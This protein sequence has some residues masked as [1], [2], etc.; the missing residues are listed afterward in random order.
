MTSVRSLYEPIADDLE[1]V[2]DTL[3][4]A[5]R[6]DFVPLQNMLEQVLQRSGKRLRPAIA[7]LAGSFGKYDT[8][9]QVALATSI[10]LLHTATLVHDDVIDS[11]ATRR[12]QPTANAT[13]DNAA[14]VMLGDYMFAHAAELVAR[15]GNL[16]VIRLFAETLMTMAKGEL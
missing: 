4:L 5:T 6:S 3:Q 16:A 13:F 15:T 8:D 10:E 12:G 9:K 1:L 11:A 7:L 14:S 2:E